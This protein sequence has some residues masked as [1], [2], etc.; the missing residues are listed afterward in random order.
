M[1]SS[2]KLSKTW[3]EDEKGKRSIN[4]LSLGLERYKISVITPSFNNAIFIEKAIN[5]VI[6]QNYL[7]CEH[8]IVDGGSTDGT[9]EILNKYPHLIWISE[10]DRGQSHAM[11]KGFLMSSGEIISYLNADDFYEDNV[12][13]EVINILNRENGILFVA[14]ACNM[15]DTEGK[16]YIPGEKPRVTFAEMMHWWKSWFPINPS[17]YFYFRE[18]Q[19]T[20]GG[21]NEEEHYM[22]DYDFLLRVSLNYKMSAVDHTWGNFR[23]HEKSKSLNRDKNITRKQIFK[24][25]E[26]SLTL[27]ERI[28]ILFHCMFD[29][30]A[31]RLKKLRTGVEKVI[32]RWVKG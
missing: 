27:S 26:N 25:Y 14:G 30:V 15:L 28:E 11:N 6:K 8:I 20:V 31:E 29:S 24:I 12:F 5:S 19:E 32:Y 16:L 3:S 10:R 17:A 9:I 1:T 7:N 18:V 22:M 21:F 2:K 23:W 13:S 4:Y